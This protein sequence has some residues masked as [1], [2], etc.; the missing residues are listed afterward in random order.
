MSNYDIYNETTKRIIDE[1]KQRLEYIADTWVEGK[2][3]MANRYLRTIF[4]KYGFTSDNIVTDELLE[5]VGGLVGKRLK[6][7]SEKEWKTI[8]Q[9]PEYECTKSGEVRRIG[10]KRTIKISENG[11]YKLSKDGKIVTVRQIDVIMPTWYA[12]EK[13]EQNNPNDEYFEFSSS[14]GDLDYIM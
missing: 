3:D 7:E 9:F 1:E 10:S 13:V 6:E 4:M 8:E 5:Y 2:E 12:N 14:L 11:R